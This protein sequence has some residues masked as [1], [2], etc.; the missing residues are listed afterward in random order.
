MAQF[1]ALVTKSPSK[2]IS[3]S[4]DDPDWSLFAKLGGKP[5][6]QERIRLR[7]VAPAASFIKHNSWPRLL[8]NGLP[9]FARPIRFN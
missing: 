3:Y 7:L 1:A 5:W 6:H 9:G 2:E 8:K 4:L